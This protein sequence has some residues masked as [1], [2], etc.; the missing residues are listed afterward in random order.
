MMTAVFAAMTLGELLG[1][2]AGDHAGIRVT[3]LVSDSRQVTPGAAFVAL[4]GDRHHGL[5]FADLALADGAR[6][7]VYEPPAPARS[8]PAPAVELPGLGQRLGDLGRRFFGRDRLPDHLI[9]VTGTNGKTTVAWLVSQGLTG[10]D[11]PCGYLGTIGYGMPGNLHPQALTTP[12]CLTLHR[13]LAEIGMP[14]TAVEVSS[15]ALAQDRIAGLG[16]EVAVFTNL[17]RDHLDW[18][19]SMENYFDAKARLFEGD[20]LKLAVVNV[21]DSH[22]ERLLGRLAATTR[23][24]PVALDGAAPAEITARMESRG[25]DGFRL[26]LDGALGRARIETSL[27]GDFN[28]ENLALA[29]ATLAALGHEIEAAADALSKLRAP[30]GRMEVFGGPPDR[31]WVIVDY[32]HT[33]VALAR[34]LGAIAAMKPGELVCVFGCGGDRDRGKRAPMGAAAARFADRIVLTDDN[35][36]DED[37]EGIIADIRAGTSGHADVHVE[38]RRELAIAQAVQSAKPGDIVLVAGKG[39]ET[40]QLVGS[41]VSAF[42][43]RAIV[44][45][46]LEGA[47]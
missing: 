36:R 18:H 19:G 5:E 23:A 3:D 38:H 8:V 21:G 17:S 15:H 4:A 39:H 26:H 7:V 14:R 46:T 40:R 12:D 30:P 44:R 10:L 35:P 34:V 47:S 22:G 6:V 37:P 33:P 29:A 42:D 45:R 2:E 28:A 9:G 41:N 32:A 20:A 43:D 25:L 31:P 11:E 27:I 1:P 13:E 24:I 16:F